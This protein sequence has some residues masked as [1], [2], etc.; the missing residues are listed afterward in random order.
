M[1]FVDARNQLKATVDF[2]DAKMSGQIELTDS[3]NP[4]V[5]CT[6]SGNW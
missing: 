2:Q 1:T 4:G 3:K 6:I 5:M